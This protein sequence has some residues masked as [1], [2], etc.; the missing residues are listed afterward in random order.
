M[1]PAWRRKS[2]SHPA[3]DPSAV[4]SALLGLLAGLAHGALAQPASPYAEVG[5][6]FMQSFAPDN[7]EAHQQNWDVTQDERGLLYVANGSGVL[8]YDGV[9]W[10]LLRTADPGVVRSVAV[11]PAGRIFTG[12]VAEIGYFAPDP[13]GRLR[14][15]SLIEHIPEEDRSF[16]DVW[17]THAL[18]DG[19]YFLSDERLFRWRDGRIKVWRPEKRFSRALVLHGTLY[20]VVG[21]GRLFMMDGERLALVPGGDQF[22]GLRVFALV[23]HGPDSVIAVTRKHGL[24][25]CRLGPPEQRACEPHGPDLTEMLAHIEPYCAVLLTGEILAIGTR[26]GGLVLIDREAR[27]IRVLTEASGLRS[28]AVWDAYVDRQGG[29]WLAL[30]DGMARIEVTPSLSYFDATSGLPETVVFVARHRGRLYA[31]TSRGVSVLEPST[32]TG[33]RFVP[34]PGVTTFC[35]SLV[36]TDEGLLAGCEEGVYNLD[37]RQRIWEI[38]RRSVYSLLRSR[39]DPTQLYLGLRDGFA[40]LTLEAGAWR[41][42]GRFEE[43]WEQ[44]RTIAEDDQGRLWL[45]TRAEG[46]LQLEAGATPSSVETASGAGA[47]RRYGVEDGLPTGWLETDT[48]AGQVKVMSTS[49]NR[50]FRFDSQTEK[51]VPDDTLLQG[52]SGIK[53]LTVDDQGRVWTVADEMSAVAS[54][55]AEGSTAFAPTALR[56]IPN[57]KPFEIIAESGGSVWVAGPQGLIRLDTESRFEPEADYPVW[58][59]RVTAANGSSLYDGPHGRPDEDPVWA[60][61]NNALRFAFA[62]PRFDGPEHTRY[63][64]RLEGFDRATTGEDWSAWTSETYKDYTNLW[65]GRYVFRVEARDVYGF[66]SREDSFAFRILPPWYRSWWAYGLYGL[67]LA[68]MVLAFVRFQRNKL[69][70]EQAINTRLREVDKLKDEIL[71]N[72]SHELRTPLFGITGL[73]ESLIDGVAGELPATAKANLEMIAGSGRRLGRL[74]NDILDHSQLTKGSLRLRRGPVDLRFLAE[75]VLTLQKPLAADKGLELRSAVPVDLPA[76]DADE[77]RLEQILHNLVG[78]AVKF[79]AEG[80]VEVFAVLRGEQVEVVVE[81]TGI[82]IGESERERI[83]LA[84][85]QVDSG[86]RRAFGGTGLGLAVTRRLV[87]MHGGS[88]EVESV[89]GEGARFAFTLPVSRDLAQPSERPVSRPLNVE[90]VAPKEPVSPPV[91]PPKGTEAPTASAPM[92]DAHGLPGARILVVDDE[93][94]NRMVLSLYLVSEG[95]EVD[96]VESGADALRLLDEQSFD[97]VLL[98]VMMPK[99]S[100]YEACRTLRRHYPLEELPVI[101]LTAKNQVSDLVE[102]LDAGGNDYVAKP[103]DKDELVARV[104][105]HLELLSVHRQ[106]KARNAELARFN[107]SIA[108][109]LKNP[110][111]TILNYLGMVQQDVASGST[112]RL[113]QDLEHLEAAAQ[114][115]CRQLDELFELTRVGVRPN[116]P[117]EIALGE[118]VEEALAELAEPISKKGVVV[119]VSDELPDVVGDRAR[120][121]EAVR[122]LLAN[123]VSYMGQPATPKIEVSVRREPAGAAQAVTVRDNGVGI[124]PKYHKKIFDLFERLEPEASEGTGIGLTLVKRIVEIHG[125]RVWVESEGRGRGSTFC[126]T[127]PEP[128]GTSPDSY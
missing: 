59:R 8:Q 80:H 83:F 19:V 112:E 86:D 111:T 72:T 89:A 90:P 108:H 105:T 56:R 51:F 109:D 97:L 76:V 44:V 74:V 35:W 121:K 5:H 106:L 113:E 63:R 100:G 40:R 77:A 12:A 32:D 107:Y 81:D 6:F 117:E 34:V 116:P 94:V 41:E 71:A 73:A 118:L 65:E 126:F 75:T 1:R 16:S 67:A 61:E 82:G 60:F 85:E 110:L 7:N 84:F 91:S 31:A 123:A 119:E 57:L 28:D 53:E 2:D 50:V 14:Y 36:S 104:R 93:P 70:R 11:G 22:A 125:G 43:V 92:A 33:P 58:I 120:I 48:V 24:V 38:P 102:G 124:D 21:D 17:Q 39:H 26:R 79:T 47:L 128:A 68:A 78:N 114:K 18:P 96:L 55:T 99:M 115:L 13:Q 46:V 127:L 9:S 49:Q 29:L 122:H 27:L 95:Y 37:W 20:V 88:I 62:A 23:P 42:G 52:P 3:L 87:E 54:P 30:N 66:V 101:F 98:D 4:R 10:R 15:A 25:R 64:T 45:G 69:Q 103:V